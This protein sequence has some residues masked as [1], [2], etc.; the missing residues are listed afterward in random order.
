[1]HLDKKYPNDSV[2]PNVEGKMV[3]VTLMVPKLS[4]FSVLSLME[5]F[6]IAEHQ[7]GFDKVYL[8][9]T[10]LYLSHPP[11]TALWHLFISIF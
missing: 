9:V 6:V 2:L 4:N 8:P 10:L 1:M 5:S 3:F 11:V 7:Q